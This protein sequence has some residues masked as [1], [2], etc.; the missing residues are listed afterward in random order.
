MLEM[1]ILAGTAVIFR[2]AFEVETVH[3]HLFQRVH[4]PNNEVFGFWETVIMVWVLGK[5]MIIRYLDPL[6]AV[7]LLG[8]VVDLQTCNC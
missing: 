7:P 2:K 1:A 3:D 8:R 5:Y 4:V 6:N